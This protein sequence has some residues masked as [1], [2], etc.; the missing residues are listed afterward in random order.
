LP[1]D[2]SAC[3]NVKVLNPALKDYLLTHSYPEDDFTSVEKC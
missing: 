3:H 1:T 2:R